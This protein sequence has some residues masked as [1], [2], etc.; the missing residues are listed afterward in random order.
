MFVNLVRGGRRCRLCW[1]VAICAFGAV[2]SW[3]VD[4]VARVYVNQGVRWIGTAQ[5]CT[6]PRG[7]TPAPL[8]GSAGLPAPLARLCVYTWVGANAPSDAEVDALFDTSGASEMTEDVP[9]TLQSAPFSSQE[10]ALF[11]GLRGALLAQVGDV[12]LMPSLTAQ[13]R[14]RIVVIDSA[15]DAP[16]HQIRRGASR[17]GDTLA[18]LIE[19]LVCLPSQSPRGLRACA[20]E[21]TTALALPGGTGTLSELARAIERAVVTWQSDRH[22]APSS[23]PERLLLNL[24]LGWEN[25]PG[26][27][28]CAAVPHRPEAPP[29]RAVRGILTHAARAG[30]LIVAA[31]GNDSGGPA[32]RT[33]LLCPAL[34][35]AVP[36]DAAGT[37]SLVVAVSGVDYRDHPLETARPLG[38]TGIAALGLGGVAWDPAD[39]VPP[40]L[41][42]SS[43]ATAVVSAVSAL[44]WAYQPTWKPNEITEAV[45]NGGIDVGKANACPIE[46]GA[47]RSHRTS[48]CGALNAAGAALSCVPAAPQSS[49]SPPLPVEVAELEAA[50]ASSSPHN[51]SV[52]G[53]PVTTPRQAA[54]TL[55]LRPWV[56][57]MPIAETCPV[58]RFVNGLLSIPARDHD[59]HDAV[60]VV[61]LADGT[62]QV[63]ALESPLHSST[64]YTFALAPPP[65]TSGPVQSAYITAYGPPP[66]TGALYSVTEQIFVQP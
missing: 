3:T 12:S 34:Y 42:G 41:T 61:G 2:T 64:A 48:T 50:F 9:V 63:V 28:D 59:L 26:I 46:L 20:A 4:A 23:T 25:A 45:Y 7:W 6:A 56:G 53:P 10:A 27:A 31:A 62:V 13:P 43:V 65:T 51:G 54:P 38:I 30:A 40:Q 52:S 35:Q 39:P 47:C 57:P 22:R 60:L 49:S 14:V 16:A 1:F 66:P 58:C 17:H 19:D 36:G 44:V 5:S 15:P 8:F 33:G 37:R 24:S 21:V 32:P 29:A 11:A 55:Q 18:H